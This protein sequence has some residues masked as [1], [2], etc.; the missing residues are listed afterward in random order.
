MAAGAVVVVVTVRVAEVGQIEFGSL[1]VGAVLQLAGAGRPIDGAVAVLGRRGGLEGEHDVRLSG[2]DRVDPRRV[3]ADQDDGGVEQQ[4]GGE[5]NQLVEGQRGGEEARQEGQPDQHR[6]VDA[7]RDVARLVEVVGQHSRLER[8][9]RAHYD[10][11]D[12]E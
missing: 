2:V 5:Q 7:Q 9:V 3:E 1:F 11:Q 10:E 6:R 4:S 8:V 12:V